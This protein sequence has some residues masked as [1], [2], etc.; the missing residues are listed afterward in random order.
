[1]SCGKSFPSLERSTFCVA[2][3]NDLIFNFGR[4]LLIKKV[5]EVEGTDGT[6]MNFNQLSSPSSPA[7]ITSFEEFCKT[8]KKKMNIDKD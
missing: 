3:S 4:L 8:Q 1:M 7:G 6:S 2:Y 5:G